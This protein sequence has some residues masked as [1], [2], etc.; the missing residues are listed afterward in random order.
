MSI[1]PRVEARLSESA[2]NFTELWTAEVI[3]YPFPG[4]QD[5]F[6]KK[7]FRDLTRSGAAGKKEK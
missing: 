5:K 2:I 1:E 6:Q 3:N 4:N 7:L